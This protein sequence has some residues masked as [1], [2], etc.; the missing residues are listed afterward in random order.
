VRRRR[1]RARAALTRGRPPQIERGCAEL[2]EAWPA[3]ARRAG[4]AR[5][6]PPSCPISAGCG[7]R[8]VH[9]VRGGGGGGPLLRSGPAAAVPAA[10]R[11]GTSPPRDGAARARARQ[12]LLDRGADIESQAREPACAARPASGPPLRPAQRGTVRLVRGEGR[13][14][15][16]L[17]GV[18]DAACPIGTKGGGAKR[19]GEVQAP[20]GAGTFRGAALCTLRFLPPALA[21]NPKRE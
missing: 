20:R 15:S 21:G 5:R 12:A 9:L 16:D 11:R 4:R 18:R 7:T 8:R 17:Y 10:R 13:G 6:R 14:V 1:A 19:S 2:V 3:P